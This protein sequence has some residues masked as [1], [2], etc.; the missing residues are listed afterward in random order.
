M[1]NTVG[2]RSKN[3]CRWKQKS[4]KVVEAEMCNKVEARHLV[5][6]TRILDREK[7]HNA[8]SV[9]KEKRAVK[10]AMEAMKVCETCFDW[11]LRCIYTT[12]HENVV[13]VWLRTNIHLQFKCNKQM[14]FRTN[15]HMRVILFQHYCVKCNCFPFI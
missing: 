6:I 12:Q 15:R 8:F 7:A 3:S 5:L 14:Q 2:P 1:A 11:M 9:E 4:S 13:I 10:G